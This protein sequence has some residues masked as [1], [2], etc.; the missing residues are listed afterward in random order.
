MT[1]LVWCIFK[2]SPQVLEKYYAQLGAGA[3]AALV[4][5]GPEPPATWEGEY[6]GQS[7]KGGSKAGLQLGT[8]SGK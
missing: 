2:G 1:T 4:Q 3:E 8:V 7:Q 5:A 6:Q